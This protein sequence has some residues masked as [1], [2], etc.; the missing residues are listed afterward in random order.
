MTEHWADCTDFRLG[1]FLEADFFGYLFVIW[2]YYI[3]IFEDYFK[4]CV[5]YFVC[6]EQSDFINLKVL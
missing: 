2:H 5:F 3:Y 1:I 6:Y 4:T